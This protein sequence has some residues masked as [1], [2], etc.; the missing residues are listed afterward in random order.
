MRQLLEWNGQLIIEERVPDS[1]VKLRK[2]LWSQPHSVAFNLWFSMLDDVRYWS[3]APLGAVTRKDSSISR[4]T[5][6]DASIKEL[7]HWLAEHLSHG[8]RVIW[9]IA[10]YVSSLV[11]SYLGFLDF[12]LRRNYLMRA[13]VYHMNL[14]W[15]NYWFF[16]IWLRNLGWWYIKLFGLWLKLWECC[17][18]CLYLLTVSQIL[19]L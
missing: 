8:D 2:L 4:Q 5:A 12:N 6:T 13:L 3:V 9:A 18:Q 17:C 16:N 15:C 1:C 11:V 7:S 19:I 10:E 14:A